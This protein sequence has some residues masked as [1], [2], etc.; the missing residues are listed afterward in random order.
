MDWKEALLQVVA[1]LIIAV[2]MYYMQYV[3]C[4]ASWKLAGR[5]VK[6][7]APEEEKKNRKRK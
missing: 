4:W 3:I 5:R 6:V 2:G 7:Q 1:Q